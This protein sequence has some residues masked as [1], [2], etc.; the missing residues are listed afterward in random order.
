V[1]D[2]VGGSL[3]SIYWMFGAHDGI[4]IIDVPDSLTAAAVSLTAA[5][6]GAFKHMETHEL[7]TQNQLSE[8]LTRAKDA[9]QRFQPPGQQ[10]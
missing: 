7:F 10:G 9:K 1:L 3:D 2:S 8:T 4:A 6:S 5:S